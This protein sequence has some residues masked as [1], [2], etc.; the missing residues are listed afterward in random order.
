M[1]NI[2]TIIKNIETHQFH[3]MEGI[4][5]ILG[6]IENQ[7]IDQVFINDITITMPLKPQGEGLPQDE[8]IRQKIVDTSIESKVW[9]G[10]DKSEGKEQKKE[11]KPDVEFEEIKGKL[12]KGVRRQKFI[13]RDIVAGRKLTLDA[14]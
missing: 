5:G 8:V 1:D 13:A 14:N 7:I 6:N 10:M 12:L 11:T 2:E 9:G 3:D 4:V